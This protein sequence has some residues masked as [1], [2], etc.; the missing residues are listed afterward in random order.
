MKKL[1]I[2]LFITSI[3][4]FQYVNAQTV[5]GVVISSED[6][7]PLPGVNVQLKGTE[8]GTITDLNGAY[9]IEAGGSESVLVFSF[10]GF[11]TQEVVVG[12]QTTIDITLEVESLGIDEI[13]VTGYGVQKKSLV[14]GAIAKVN[15]EEL[16]KGADLKVN[17]ALQGKT[18][19]V[20]IS[21]NS[22]QP[23]EFVSVRIRGTGTNGDAEPLYIVDGLPTNGWGIDYLSPQDIESIE[24]LKDAASSSIYGARGA[25]GV[26][27]ITTKKGK[28]GTKT[29]FTYDGYYGLQNPWRKI[30]VLEKDDYIMLINEMAANNNQPDVFSPA[31]IDTLA[32]TDWQDQM[33]YKNAPK[34]NHVLTMTGGSDKMTFSSSLSYYN[35]DGIVAKGYSNFERINYRLNTTAD[36]GFLE[37]GASLNISS[38]TSKGIAANDQYAGTSLDQALNMPPIVAVKLSDGSWGT[39]TAYGISMQEITNPIAML[40]YQNSETKTKKL[41]GGISGD[42]DFGEL[43]TAL[44]GLKFRT[45]FSTEFTLGANRYYT[46]QY[47]LDPL[48]YSAV[49]RV[50]NT[51]NKWA[52]WNIDNT[53]TY[54]KTI[55]ESNFTIL[56]GHS[57]FREWSEDLGGSKDN[58]IFNTYDKAYINNAVDN[59]SMNVWGGFSDHTLLSYFGRINYDYAGKYMLTAILRADGSSRFGSENKFGYFPSVSLGWV[60]SKESFMGFMGDAVNFAKLRISWG[61]NGNENIG[62]FNYMSV[63]SNNSIYYYGLNKTQ[64]NGAQPSKIANPLLKWETS[65]QFNIGLDFQFMNN[66]LSFTTD[67]YSKTTKDWL[68]NAPAPAMIGNNPPTVNGGDVQNRGIE[69]EFGYREKFGEFHIDIDLTGGFNQNEVLD[70]PNQEKMLEGGTGGHGQ[71]GIIVAKV[72]EP[73]GYFSG[74]ETLGLFQTQEDLDEHIDAQPNAKLG[75]IIFKDQNNDGVL[76]DDD[77]VKLG[78]PNPDFTGGLN[79]S[80]DWKG[81]DLNMFWYTALGQQVWNATYRYDLLYANYKYEALGRWT[82]PGTS[83]YFPRLTMNDANNNWKTASDFFVKDASFVRLRNLSLG[84]TLPTNLSKVAKISKIRIY[85]AAE[86]LLTFTKY[87]GFDPEIG[88]G[89]FSLGID[90]GVYPQARTF[91][92]GL[93]ITF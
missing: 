92:G 89:P 7:Q 17:Q 24:V 86:N 79:I 15:G 13:V 75:D 20:V 59:A 40:S 36:F 29:Q 90:H 69:F 67:L 78:D 55:G 45:S 57:A 83:N 60:F 38:M 53:F 27:L 49:D 30:G 80:A 70:I 48:H 56:L 93:S 73:M 54:D 16:T 91:L 61:Q 19:G 68:I 22:G 5:Q 12:S 28:K 81:F 9:T 35:Q 64:Y 6:G 85:I 41:I 43:F 51:D 77:R 37:V 50:G 21:T 31:M 76:N 32:N 10:M 42:F 3:G 72:G 34:M 26:I 87:K 25:N 1:L 44:K 52:R 58:L 47:F 23:G 46:P 39:P 71:S 63:M 33:F 18:A 62:D 88:G 65:E 82:G 14:T 2:Y 66:K 84:Y 11:T 74:Y 4:L 8:K